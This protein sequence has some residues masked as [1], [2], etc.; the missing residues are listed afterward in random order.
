MRY[1]LIIFSICLLSF[2]GR[3]TIRYEQI[4]PDDYADA[5]KF[6]KTNFDQ[7]EIASYKYR[8]G[9][10]FSSAIVFPELMR[11]SVIKDLFETTALELMYVEYG[12]KAADFSIG[13]FQMKAS[14]IESL[15]EE[16]SKN[17]SL[18]K[19]YNV[20]FI[21]KNRNDREKRQIRVN[22]LKT[23]NWQITYLHAFIAIC[24]MRFKSF[25]TKNINQKLVL[26]ATAYNSGFYQKP[27]TLLA[28]SENRCFPYGQKFEGTQYS[29]SDIANYYFNYNH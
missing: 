4:F 11:Y 9:M 16:I 27:E 2:S 17:D 24:D 19:L 14:F 21:D 7:L 22:R 10:L 13:R 29:Y 5:K 23:N 1:F 25:K 15:E 20:I 8:H 26:Y 3:E 12:K 6:L 18:Q 28:K